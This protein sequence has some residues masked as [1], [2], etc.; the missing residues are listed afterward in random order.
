MRTI[1]PT[2]TDDY[3]LRPLGTR[4][5]TRV[6]TIVHAWCQA[7]PRVGARQTTRNRV[8]TGRRFGMPTDAT[9]GDARCG[10]R[11]HALLVAVVKRS[12]EIIRAG[13]GDGCATRG[14]ESQVNLAGRMAG[15]AP[16]L[17]AH[18]SLQTP[19]AR[20]LRNRGLP[21]HATEMRRVKL[22]PTRGLGRL[23]LTLSRL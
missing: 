17:E 3:G 6:Q 21:V 14:R 9:V 10:T 11:I 2:T 7:Q 16:P 23:V 15:S 22:H 8:H 4:L 1:W 18:N 20:P 19:R 12:T 5:Q 13:M